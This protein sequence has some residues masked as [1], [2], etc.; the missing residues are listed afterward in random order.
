MSELALYDSQG[1][2]IGR[3]E[4]EQNQRI[5][6]L[7]FDGVRL[8]I[9]TS[10]NRPEL[11]CFF[12]AR[13]SSSSRSEQYYAIYT[14]D[15]TS[16]LSGFH[17]Q[18]E[19]R[20]EEELG[21]SIITSTEDTEV[22]EYLRSGS[23][24]GVQ[25]TE[26]LDDTLDL[27]TS[28]DTQSRVGGVEPVQ[29]EPESS[30]LFGD[31]TE[32][33]TEPVD[34]D[35]AKIGVGSYRDAV[36]VVQYFLDNGLN[37][38]KI[39]SCVIA[40]NADSSRLREY[41]VVIEKGQYI[42]V[43]LF[44]ETE[45]AI[46]EMKERR[47][48]KFQSNSKNSSQRRRIT[49]VASLSL[50]F[51][52]FMIVGIYLACLSG[53]PL[54]EFVPGCGET[55]TDEIEL[56]AAEIDSDGLILTGEIQ[57]GSER[58]NETVQIDILKNSSDGNETE[59]H[60]VNQTVNSGSFEHRLTEDNLSNIDL[61]E[62]GSGQYHVVVSH[63]KVED[64]LAIE[65]A[66]PALS[67]R[68]AQWEGT[69]RLSVNGELATNR[70]MADDESDPVGLVDPEPEL[71]VS[72]GQIDKNVTVESYA[73]ATFEFEK[74]GFAN[75]SEGGN[76]TVAYNEVSDTQEITDSVVDIRVSTEWDDSQELSVQGTLKIN[77]ERP[78]N[79][80]VSVSVNQQGN[81][82]EKSDQTS[83]GDGTDDDSQGVFTAA[84]GV[85]ELE[86][87]GIVPEEQ[88]TVMASFDGENETDD[89]PTFERDEA[90]FSSEISSPNET[91]EMNETLKVTENESVV[92]NGTI[93][94][95]GD[96]T[97]EVDTDLSI[98]DDTDN[99]I[100]MENKSVSL[101]PQEN[102]TLTLEWETS[103]GDAGDYTAKLES[104]EE[105]LT[106]EISVQDV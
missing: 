42:G 8:A 2:G 73:N 39:S 22:F 43:E 33:D 65:P 28:S 100:R 50:A 56:T 51:V 89:P 9:D 104:N 49:N 17:K 90:T 72:V 88:M 85:D 79:E 12:R 96:E 57:T 26:M 87:E 31:S 98:L 7:F 38:G 71:D 20:V 3:H 1:N 41:D 25:Q 99:Q 93:E 13:E 102:K 86:N 45:N 74:D 5:E 78:A 48:K 103:E 55:D 97:A 84:F 94:N 62:L 106:R 36:S 47:R 83:E 27:L 54:P 53:A 4:G 21:L 69:D 95:T 76:V 77:G 34:P 35:Q 61:H 10:G 82:T 24:R 19:Q 60:S 11:I 63:D 105:T 91:L 80:Q 101:D 46:E 52:G 64:R 30:S 14:A 67:V 44:D 68:D 6:N 16:Q 40:E 23:A 81:K 75:A 59:I 58:E 66:T 18:L 70:S 15:N 32:T 29:A 37:S 92:L